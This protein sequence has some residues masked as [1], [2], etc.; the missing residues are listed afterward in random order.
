MITRPV[1]HP[2][3]LDAALWWNETRMLA[4][5]TLMDA[6][7]IQIANGTM[8]AMDIAQVEI[9][10]G[11]DPSEARLDAVASEARERVNRMESTWQPSTES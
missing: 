1:A 8:K 9:D 2:L 11:R 5:R 3:D 10:A 4:R 7:A 6:K